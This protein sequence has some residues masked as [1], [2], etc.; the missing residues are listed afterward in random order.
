MGNSCVCVAQRLLACDLF[1]RKD[2]MNVLHQFEL[3]FL[4]CIL[5]SQCSNPRSFLVSVLYSVATGFSGGQSLNASLRPYH[6][7]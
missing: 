5:N 4:L 2:S 6:L 3:Y 7:Q 1:A